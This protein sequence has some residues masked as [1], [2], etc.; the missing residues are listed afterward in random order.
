[1][2]VEKSRWGREGMGEGMRR[3]GKREGGKKS[4]MGEEGRKEDFWRKVGRQEEQL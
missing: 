2:K 4:G 1:M 3:Y